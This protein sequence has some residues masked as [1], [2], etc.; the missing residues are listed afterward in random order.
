METGKKGVPGGGN[1]RNEGKEVGSSLVHKE[2]WFRDYFRDCEDTHLHMA[3]REKELVPS[4]LCL[5]P[6]AHSGTRISVDSGSDTW[7]L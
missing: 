2:P 7:S 5:V 1:S 6:E 4:L 3:C